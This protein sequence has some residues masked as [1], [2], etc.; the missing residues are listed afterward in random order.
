MHRVG[1]EDPLEKEENVEEDEISGDEARSEDA[2]DY[3]G[4]FIDDSSEERSESE[5]YYYT[6]DPV[7]DERNLRRRRLAGIGAMELFRPYNN[8]L[9]FITIS[10]AMTDYIQRNF[11]GDGIVKITNN[12][13]RIVKKYNSVVRQVWAVYGLTTAESRTA[14]KREALLAEVLEDIKNAPFSMDSLDVSPVQVA[15]YDEE[16]RR[17]M[18][19]FKGLD[20]ST[21]IDFTI[22]MKL[23]FLPEDHEKKLRSELEAMIFKREIAK[24]PAITRE[25]IREA[26]A[27]EVD[28]RVDVV[29]REYEKG[30]AAKK[31]MYKAFGV[32]ESY[33]AAFIPNAS[34]KDKGI[35][36]KAALTSIEDVRESAEEYDD[37][38]FSMMAKN[39]WIKA[40]TLVCTPEYRNIIKKGP[41]STKD[42]D[43][44]REN[45]L[46]CELAVQDENDRERFLKAAFNVKVIIA[47]RARYLLM[48]ENA[49]KIRNVITRARAVASRY[50]CFLYRDAMDEHEGVFFE[51]HRALFELIDV[52]GTVD[53]HCYWHITDLANHEARVAKKRA[54]AAEALASRSVEPES[55][56]ER[57]LPLAEGA[58]YAPVR[59]EESALAQ[60][61]SSAG[62]G[63]SHAAGEKPAPHRAPKKPVE[64]HPEELRLTK[65]AFTRLYTAVYGDSY[66]RVRMSAPDQE[67]LVARA[68]DRLDTAAP[69]P[70]KDEHKTR[71]FALEES[72][73]TGVP[74]KVLQR[75]VNRAAWM[76]REEAAMLP[77]V[78]VFE[79]TL[80]GRYKVRLHV[81]SMRAER[82]QVDHTALM[83][84]LR[85]SMTTP[86]S[87]VAFMNVLER[88]IGA[89]L[90]GAEEMP[91]KGGRFVHERRYDFSVEESVFGQD[92]A[93]FRAAL[94]RIVRMFGDKIV[95]VHT[96]GSFAANVSVLVPGLAGASELPVAVDS[97]KSSTSREEA[98]ALLGTPQGPLTSVWHGLR[99][100]AV[101]V[102][103]KISGYFMPAMEASGFLLPAPTAAMEKGLRMRCRLDLPVKWHGS[104]KGKTIVNVDIDLAVVDDAGLAPGGAIHDLIRA[105]AVFREL[106]MA[107]GVDFSISACWRVHGKMWRVILAVLLK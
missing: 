54:R 63:P 17:Y 26:F 8:D 55:I 95:K 12:L 28:A 42:K 98:V 10:A 6:I 15:V 62:S 76:A 21:F 31:K 25:S 97:K 19:Y 80:K 5:E 94:G 96:T 35:K 53:D 39:H 68:F 89:A 78:H 103:W 7:S 1:D 67:A 30:N 22:S 93:K 50:G 59:P 85:H 48:V 61:V 38:K 33:F 102:A 27:K 44:Y 16:M 77:K 74:V 36:I 18:D 58:W 90:R 24:N 57:R 20:A 86:S 43:W 56:S 64:L 83:L 4:S 99:S 11:D 72:L 9:K 47:I 51:R 32:D 45:L 70:F 60:F 34:K 81:R 73:I 84:L 104:V 101:G 87:T 79:R 41:E 66:S 71:A 92:N 105:V 13:K 88:N 75:C 40:R 2:S 46:L 82:D 29:R 100:R 91:A 49:D 69:K 107:V 65:L 106:Y 23:K 14:E 52:V 37:V 3:T